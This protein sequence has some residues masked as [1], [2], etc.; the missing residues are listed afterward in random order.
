MLKEE[1]EKI[2]LRGNRA[3]WKR[4]MDEAIKQLGYPAD[5]DGTIPLRSAAMIS[6]REEAVAVL[7]QICD[8]FGDNDWPDN[9][10]LADIIEKH[11]GNHLQ[12]ITS[13]L[14]KKHTRVD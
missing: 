12:R 2:W 1:D 5:E 4:I 9:L 11:L 14:I 3:A 6:E 10:N 7:R 13:I 8:D